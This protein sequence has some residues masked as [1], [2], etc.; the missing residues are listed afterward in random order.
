VVT[1]VHSKDCTDPLLTSVVCTGINLPYAVASVGTR[2]FTKF[3][4]LEERNVAGGHGTVAARH[5]S[6]SLSENRSH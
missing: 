4:V 5:P 6:R 3:A 1:L 2:R